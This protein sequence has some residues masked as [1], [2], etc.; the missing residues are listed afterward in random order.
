MDRSIFTSYGKALVSLEQFCAHSW[1]SG[2]EV[3]RAESENELAR[4]RVWAGNV[5]AHQ[6]GKVSLDH[7]L[8]EAS[9]Y[10]DRV[11]EL[12]D[13]LTYTAEKGELAGTRPSHGKY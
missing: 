11:V 6:T 12:L 2:T 9:W 4:L 13:D 8:R 10:R 7:R 5:G 3:S 1:A